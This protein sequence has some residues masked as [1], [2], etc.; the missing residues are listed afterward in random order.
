ML[1]K[2]EIE[3]NRQEYFRQACDDIR[4]GIG[5]KAVLLLLISMTVNSD[6]DFDL[7]EYMDSSSPRVR[8]A[9]DNLEK[10]GYIRTDREDGSVEMKFPQNA[11]KER[12]QK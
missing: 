1:D 7:R 4:L 9:M 8:K 5:E 3:G 12:R 2:K 11:D 10:Y 6:P